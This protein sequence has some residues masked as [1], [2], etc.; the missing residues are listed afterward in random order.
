MTQETL[1]DKSKI[2]R[3]HYRVTMGK[4]ASKE[5]SRKWKRLPGCGLGS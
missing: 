5:N 2:L 3:T 1:P 4:A